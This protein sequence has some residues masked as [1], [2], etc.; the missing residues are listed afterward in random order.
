[1]TIENTNPPPADDAPFEAFEAWRAGKALDNGSATAQ[2]SNADRLNAG[3]DDGATAA[4]EPEDGDPEGLDDT[5]DDLEGGAQP[6]KRKGGWQRRVDKLTRDL[7]DLNSDREYWRQ[8]VLL[9]QQQQLGAK[10]PKE[11]VQEQAEPVDPTKP[12]LDD[13]DSIADHAQAVAEWTIKKFQEKQAE[14]AYNQQVAAKAQEMRA[15]FQERLVKAVERYPDYAETVEPIRNIPLPPHIKAAL[16]RSDV[17]PDIVY[18]VFKNP[19]LMQEFANAEGTQQLVLLG[20]VQAAVRQ[21]LASQTGSATET[22]E[23]VTRAPAPLQTVRSTG[24]AVSKDP[25]KMS[26]EEFE[27]WRAKNTKPR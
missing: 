12:K 8:Q 25:D 4:P 22:P 14:E 7:N 9:L 21:K 2:N 26:F 23:V 17:G 5:S 10:P 15:G 13:Y 16:M 1:M 20:Q 19:E 6:G 18:H 27:A 24:A 3:K 11:Q